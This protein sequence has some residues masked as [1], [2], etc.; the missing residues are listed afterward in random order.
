MAKK[1]NST[2]TYSKALA[3]LAVFGGLFAQ[4]GMFA[5]GRGLKTS[6]KCIECGRAHRH[7]NAFC[8]TDCCADWREENPKQGRANH[9]HGAFG[10]AFRSI[11]AVQ[12]K[13]S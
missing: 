6:K 4:A 8:D 2:K 11:N 12:E 9:Y 1:K 10:A 13:L 3:A 5:E 7:N